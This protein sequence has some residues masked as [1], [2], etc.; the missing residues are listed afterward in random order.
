MEKDR[1][2]SARWGAKLVDRF[3]VVGIEAPSFSRCE[4]RIFDPEL[5]LAISANRGDDVGV[6]S[7][8]EPL[9]LI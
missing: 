5:E 1:K 4:S 9:N 2:G 3:V 7:W 8:R 6:D